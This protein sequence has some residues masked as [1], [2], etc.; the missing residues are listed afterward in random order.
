[1]MSGGAI[2]ATQG[3]TRRQQNLS[4]RTLDQRLAVRIQDKVT[5]QKKMARMT[6]AA[7]VTVWVPPGSDIP[8]DHAKV[9]EPCPVLARRFPLTTIGISTRTMHTTGATSHTMGWD[10]I[11]ATR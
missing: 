1:M 2:K 4:A 5:M 9:T 3:I 11:A 10:T 7:T 8:K 6:T